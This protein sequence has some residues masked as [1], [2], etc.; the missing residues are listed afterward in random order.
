VNPGVAFT[1]GLLHDIGKAMISDFLQ[2]DIEDI[3]TSLEHRELP[4]YRT[5]EQKYLGT[6]HCLT[7]YEMA[8]HWHLP[9]PLRIGIKFH[10]TPFDA[11]GAE[12]PMAYV[13]HLAD[14]LVMLHGYGTGAD[15]PHYSLDRSY[16]EFVKITDDE[17]E[18]VIPGL[19]DEFDNTAAILF[20]SF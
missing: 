16:K 18:Q 3:L 8:N 2:N 4:D 10:H 11:V 12:K 13:V 14:M 19:Q 1:S 7:G 17:L 5:A 9:F 20:S 15:T 6:D